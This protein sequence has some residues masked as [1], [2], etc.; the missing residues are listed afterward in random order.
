MSELMY[1]FSNGDF[2]TFEQYA[3]NSRGVIVHVQTGVIVS[4]HNICG[5][6]MA[7]LSNNDGTQR[8]ISVARAIASTFLEPPSKENVVEH[9]DQNTSND[10][11]DNIRWLGA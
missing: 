9:I 2:Q 8:V 6:N 5:Y 11:L 4:S 10:R 1:Y 7:V 3:I